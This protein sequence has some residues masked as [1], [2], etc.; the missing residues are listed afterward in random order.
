MKSSVLSNFPK[1]K[2]VSF[3]VFIWIPLPLNQDRTCF[4]KSEATLH[5]KNKCSI[6]SISSWQKVQHG[7]SVKPN[8]TEVTHFNFLHDSHWF[9]STHYLDNDSSQSKNEEVRAICSRIVM[10]NPSAC[11]LNSNLKDRFCFSSV[12]YREDKKLSFEINVITI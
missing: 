4:Q 10:L 9:M 1:I 3:N 7:E 5:A 12:C 6:D 2:S 11:E 8:P